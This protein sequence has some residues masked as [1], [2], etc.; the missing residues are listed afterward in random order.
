MISYDMAT[1]T[2]YKIGIYGRQNHLLWWTS[3]NRRRNDAR[4]EGLRG[5][6]ARTGWQ[7]RSASGKP[8]KSIS[9]THHEDSVLAGHDSP[10]GRAGSWDEG[11][12]AFRKYTD[13]RGRKTRRSRLVYHIGYLIGDWN[14]SIYSPAGGR[15]RVG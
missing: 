1:A 15:R 9:F 5:R 6:D 13:G 4:S 3:R 11:A 12:H 10:L 7:H 14:R 2:S 8:C